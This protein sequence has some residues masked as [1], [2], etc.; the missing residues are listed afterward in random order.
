MNIKKLLNL[1]RNG[2]YCVN[3]DSISVTEDIDRCP[4]CESEK[5][6]TIKIKKDLFGTWLSWVFWIQIFT[7]LACLIST[8]I[9]YS[10]KYHPTIGVL[11]IIGIPL[12]LFS[13]IIVYKNPTLNK[14][15]RIRNPEEE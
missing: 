11:T 4:R 2:I 1:R 5:V 7:F 15:G 12:F 14:K 8:I 10:I 6:E 9:F 13:S 3:C